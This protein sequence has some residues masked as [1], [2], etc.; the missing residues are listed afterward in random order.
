MK[1]VKSAHPMKLQYEKCDFETEGKW[2]LMKHVKNIH[3]E[4]ICAV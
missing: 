2:R 1:H 4:K 3:E